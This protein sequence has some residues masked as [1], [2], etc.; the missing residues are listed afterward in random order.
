[1]TSTTDHDRVYRE[2]RFRV[3]AF[4]KERESLMPER[5][6]DDNFYRMYR[7]HLKRDHTVEELRAN[8]DAIIKMLGEV[9]Q[10]MKR[11]QL[12]EVQR[13]EKE[14]TLKRENLAKQNTEPYHDLESAIIYFK[15][16]ADEIR[17]LEISEEDKEMLLLKLN[18]KRAATLDELL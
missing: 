7:E 5:L 14:A 13:L 1:M 11:D 15:A 17:K 3:E 9:A 12:E 8:A 10:E 18:E 2:L 6:K 4:Y 16:K